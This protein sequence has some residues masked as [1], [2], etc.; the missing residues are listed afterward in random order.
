M[1]TPSPTY[2]ELVGAIEALPVSV[3]AFEREAGVAQGFVAKLKRG[4]CGTARAAASVGKLLAAL[5]ARGVQ[6]ATSAPASPPVAVALPEVETPARGPCSRDPETTP[7]APGEVPADLAQLVD[8]ATTQE[9]IGRALSAVGSG[10]LRARIDRHT[11]TAIESLLK[12]RSQVLEREQEEAARV[13]AGKPVTVTVAYEN[14][15]RGAPACSACGGTG[16]AI[17][18]GVA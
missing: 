1:K 11:G 15:W 7:A 16:R 9:L 12:T 8:D 3:R 2:P 14:D 5:E 18:S 4:D 17:G 10:V 13:D 6:V